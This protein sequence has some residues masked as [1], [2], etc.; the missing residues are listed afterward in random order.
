MQNDTSSHQL[1]LTLG[2][3]E[4]G[5]LRYL[6]SALALL[7]Y[8]SVI[9]FNVAVITAVLL[10]KSLQ[11]PMYI[12]V[13]VLCI[14]GLYGST[15]FFPSLIFNLVNHINT[16]TYTGCLTQVFCIHTYVGCEM[17]I[18]VIMAY[19]RYVCI[20]NP[21]RY[22]SIISLFVVF[23]LVALAWFYT[24]ILVG[25]HLVLTIRLPICDTVILKVY[26]D[27][28]SVVRLSCIDV[29]I[30]NGFGLFIG[31]TFI[32]PMPM[33]IIISYIQI[34]RACIRSSKGFRAK[35]LQTCTPHLITVTIYTANLFFELLI[36]RFIPESLNYEL[37]TIMSVQVVASPPLLNPL[38]YGLKLKDIKVKILRLFS[39]KT[40][41]LSV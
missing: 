10:H 26:C 13:C 41:T 16:I 27:N 1:L 37:R 36:Y 20:C 40:T 11:E 6:Y 29:T 14:N 35:A 22:H 4:M 23:K 24:I 38:I 32:G 5:S 21:L 34:L 18:L 3:R 31:S 28:W 39:L 19:D 2:F 12:F 9:M 8:I 33:L 30:N 15:S 17:T 25:L 7:V